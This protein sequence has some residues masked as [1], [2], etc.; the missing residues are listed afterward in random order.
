MR[1]ELQQAIEVE[2]RLAAAREA[3]GR[4]EEAFSHLERAHI[5]SQR[6]TIP[7][8]RSHWRMWAWAWRQRRP[9]EMLGQA[10]R[11]LAAML[12]SRIWVPEGNTGGSNVSPIM[13]MPI[14]DDLRALLSR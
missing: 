10:T 9:R 1:I 2:Y 14:P 5:L 13:P 11:I 8:M 7:H 3:E 4:P 6:F 12:F